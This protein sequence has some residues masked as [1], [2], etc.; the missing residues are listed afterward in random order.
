MRDNPKNPQREIILPSRMHRPTPLANRL[1]P[2]AI[3]NWISRGWMSGPIKNT[4]FVSDISTKAKYFKLFRRYKHSRI[5]K[6][7]S[8]PKEAVTMEVTASRRS[9]MEGTPSNPVAEVE[10][11]IGSWVA[12][13]LAPKNCFSKSEIVIPA[14][15]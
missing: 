9:G 12:S 15:G 13:Q 6:L 10:R 1:Q 3:G 7:A 8:D 11:S 14:V 5:L 2:E 4:F